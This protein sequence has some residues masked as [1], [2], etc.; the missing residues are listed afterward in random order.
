MSQVI[1]FRSSRKARA[2]QPAY[3]RVSRGRSRRKLPIQVE[4]C[5]R[6]EDGDYLVVAQAEEAPQE[7][8]SDGLGERR[9]IRL[10][11]HFRILSP[12]IPEFR[13]L[14]RDC[15]LSGLQFETTQPVP[16][17]SS[18]QLAL[19]IWPLGADVDCEVEV[20]WCERI[21]Q[22]PHRSELGHSSRTELYRVGCRFVGENPTLRASLQSFF[23]DRLQRHP[24]RGAQPLA[25]APAVSTTPPVEEQ[26]PLNAVL[27]GVSV[28]ER[29]TTVHLR[30]EQ[31]EKRRVLLPNV[32]CVKDY[33]GRTGRRIGYLACRQG[34][35][36]TRIRFLTP[37]FDKV[38]EIETGPAA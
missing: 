16:V 33:H 17:G 24:D 10:D 35:N 13:A 25:Q 22:A 20:M 23:Q 18:L 34:A 27:T 8:L 37:T 6:M 9:E 1:S 11:E 19:G 5:R 15:S 29:G 3:I 14:T 7:L 32:R 30:L 36:G 38:L 4:Y 12:D 26:A 2:G 28:D 21:Q 31:G